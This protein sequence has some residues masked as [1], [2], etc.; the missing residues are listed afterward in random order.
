MELEGL[1]TYTSLFDNLV[2]II[3]PPSL[4]PSP[5]VPLSE[6]RSGEVLGLVPKKLKGPNYVIAR[7][8][9]IA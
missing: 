4:V 7:L 6:K 1:Y 5:H 9:I 3:P 2:L 8:E